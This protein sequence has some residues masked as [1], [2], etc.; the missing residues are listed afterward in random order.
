MSQS[1]IVWTFRNRCW[2]FGLA[3]SNTGK[4]RIWPKVEHCASRICAADRILVSAHLSLR[5]RWNF[6]LAHKIAAILYKRR[7]QIKVTIKKNL[8]EYLIKKYLIHIYIV[9]IFTQLRRIKMIYMI[10]KVL[11]TL[12][13]VDRKG[14]KYYNIVIFLFLKIKLIGVTSFEFLKTYL[15]LYLE[16]KL[17]LIVYLGTCY[18]I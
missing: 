15:F 4:M 14:A 11:A 5:R 16:W 6:A 17:C 18:K 2:R 12:W 8:I 1:I 3:F 13:Q 7:Q 9:K 10:F